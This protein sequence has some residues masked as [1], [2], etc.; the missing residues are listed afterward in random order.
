MAKSVDNMDADAI[1][2]EIIEIS[3]DE[4][5]IT[6]IGYP[7]SYKYGEKINVNTTYT[8]F[9]KLIAELEKYIED[10]KLKDRI[11]IRSA[12]YSLY[13]GIDNK[14][15]YQDEAIGYDLYDMLYTLIYL[16]VRIDKVDK[17]VTGGIHNKP[18]YKF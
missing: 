8:R 3:K 15:R 14:K 10:G 17:S 4:A 12:L 13:Y 2:K 1:C 6:E 9:K 18:G 5:K 11:K 7:E 16:Y